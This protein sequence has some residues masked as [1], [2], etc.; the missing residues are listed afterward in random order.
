MADLVVFNEYAGGGPIEQIN[1]AAGSVGVGNMTL[2]RTPTVTDDSTQGY[3]VGS[4]VFDAT[5]G[6]LRWYKCRDTTAGAAKWCLDGVDYANGGTNPAIEVTQFGLGAAVLAEE[7]NI[8]RQL[9]SA[10]ISPG[11]TAAD[12]VLAVF[13]LPANSFDVAG[14]GITITAQGTFVSGAG[15]KDMKIIFNPSTAVVGSTVGAGGTTIADTGSQTTGTS[16]TGWSI[17]A[18]VFKYG[19]AASNTQLGLHQQA[20]VG[21]VVGGIVPPSLLTAVESGAI[22]I[23]V[24]GNAGTTATDIKLNFF[25][26]NAMN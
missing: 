8:S 21:S 25:E 4:R 11:A 7:G 10:G 20:Q 23:A 9:S 16:G 19:A 14:R 2:N 18:N 17:Q 3:V 15:T 13:S 1:A 26:I 24:T 12:N 5:A 22:L 6:A